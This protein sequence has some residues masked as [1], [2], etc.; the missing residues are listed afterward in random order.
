M[1]FTR[2]RVARGKSSIVASAVVLALAAAL[3]VPITAA[4]T[5][6]VARTERA[7]SIRHHS[8]L[9][10]GVA[11]PANGDSAWLFNS[12]TTR[13]LGHRTTPVAIGPGST[14]VSFAL[15][16]LA[17]GTTYYFRLI[18]IEGSY[19]S[20]TPHYGRILSFTTKP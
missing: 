19:P 16:H 10:H 5:S 18:V 6:S 15:T 12:G 8:A 14:P 13:H 9:L 11:S 17:R 7:T 20:A 4:A 1:V 2:R 3:L